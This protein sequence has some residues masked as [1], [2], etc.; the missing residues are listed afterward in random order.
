M[1]L[2]GLKGREGFTTLRAHFR[3]VYGG[4]EG[5]DS[6]ALA[7]AKNRFLE[8]LAGSSLL[9]YFLQKP[10]QTNKLAE[11]LHDIEA[12]GLPVFAR[13]NSRVIISIKTSYTSKFPI[14]QGQ[15]SPVKKRR[16]LD[17]LKK[18]PKIDLFF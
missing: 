13:E 14:V 16:F 6:P 9:C 7:A 18:G 17:P 8:S 5:D 10:A 11:V 3:R 15:N 2:D 1:S 4:D 12:F